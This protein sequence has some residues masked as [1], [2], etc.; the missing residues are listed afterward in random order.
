M[1]GWLDYWEVAEVVHASKVARSPRWGHCWRWKRE[2]GVVSQLPGDKSVMVEGWGSKV[3]SRQKGRVKRRWWRHEKRSS[4]TKFHCRSTS[5]TIPVRRGC[6]RRGY[7]R[8]DRYS[9]GEED[10]E[11]GLRVKCRS[12]GRCIRKVGSTV[13]GRRDRY[14]ESGPCGCW[15]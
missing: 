2:E 1:K 7:I 10:R 9:D 14:H 13:P 4:G 11:L 3:K 6:M 12:T 15:G 8:E 5:S